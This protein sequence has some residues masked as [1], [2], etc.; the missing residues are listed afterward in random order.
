M[1]QIQ[2]YPCD[3]AGLTSLLAA[4]L[5]FEVLCVLEG[6]FTPPSSS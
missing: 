2:S 6:D 5:L 4:N 3:F 1:P